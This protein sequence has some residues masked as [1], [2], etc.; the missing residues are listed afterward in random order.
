M[1]E[2]KDK[3]DPVLLLSS[4]EQK[5]GKR[6]RWTKAEKRKLSFLVFYKPTQLAVLHFSSLTDHYTKQLLQS[7]N[8]NPAV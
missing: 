1:D 3:R 4:A 8:L 7:E 5:T 6:R 2:W